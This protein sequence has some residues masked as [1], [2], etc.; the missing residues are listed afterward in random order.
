[1]SD[2]AIATARASGDGSALASALGARHVALWRP[3]RAEERLQ[4]ADEMIAAARVAGDRHAELQAHNW[5]AADL[6]ELGE[7]PAWR[8]E[9]ERHARLADELRLPVFQW[10]TPLWAAVDAMLA[11][12]YDEAEQLS[13]DAEAA[14][15]RAGDRNAEL[16][17]GMVRFCA[18]LER[19][20]FDEIELE[21]VEHKIASSPAGPAYRG[22]YAWVLAGLGETQR[23]RDELGA[24]MTLPQRFDA[25]WLSFQVECAEASVLIE[26]A[27]YATGLYERLAPYAGRPATAGRAVN[28]Y[29]A[30]D[31]TLAGLAALL[32]RDAEAVR[33]LEEAI[34]VNEALGCA[35]WRAHSERQLAQLVR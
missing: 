35:V 26:D 14:G 21:F 30:V 31:R 12:R 16:F 19:N 22:S 24:A 15:V 18:Q 25:N 9:T 17:P 3:D 28:S 13:A 29:G 1:L 34:R 33:H 5:R 23:A 7:M 8:E 11:G 27:T 32:G 10:Y 6:F 2:D 20:A 4:V